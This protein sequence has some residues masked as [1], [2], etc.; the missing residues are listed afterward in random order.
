VNGHALSVVPVDLT[1]IARAHL[2]QLQ[3]MHPARRVDVRVASDMTVL[4]DR[5]LLDALLANL[6]QNAWKFTGKR[7]DPCI[8]VGCERTAD[9]VAHFVRDNGAGFDMAFAAKLFGVFQRLHT[10]EEFEGNGIG[11]ATAERIVRRHGGRIWAEGQVDRGATFLFAL[12]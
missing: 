3:A 11:L 8:E 6:L 10:Q 1:A 2:D 4:G 12:P 9:G 7:Q 5:R